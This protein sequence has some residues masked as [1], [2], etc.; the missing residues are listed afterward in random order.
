VAESGKIL[1]P[2]QGTF[3]IDKRNSLNRYAMS[4]KA[5]FRCSTQ[6]RR[7][8][9]IFSR[10][11]GAWAAQSGRICRFDDKLLIHFAIECA[12]KKPAEAGFFVVVSLAF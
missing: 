2:V 9:A 6:G 1:F 11:Q 5:E 4:S 10:M 12:K 3:L 7:A 8:P